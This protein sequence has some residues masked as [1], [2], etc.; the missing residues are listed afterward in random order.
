MSSCFFLGTT[1]FILFGTLAGGIKNHVDPHHKN[2]LS[3]LQNPYV[4]S[5]YWLVSHIG[6]Y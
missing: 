4:M 2:Q 5:L 1:V 3:N 6:L